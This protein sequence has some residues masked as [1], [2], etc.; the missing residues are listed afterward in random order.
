MRSA[1]GAGKSVVNEAT[2][3][4]ETFHVVIPHGD[5]LKCSRCEAVRSAAASSTTPCVPTVASGKCG[6]GHGKHLHRNVAV[7]PGTRKAAYLAHRTQ[8]RATRDSVAKGEALPVVSKKRRVP[9]L[10]GGRPADNFAARCFWRVLRLLLLVVFLG[11]A[12]S[13]KP[14]CAGNQMASA[15]TRATFALLLAWVVQVMCPCS[16]TK[17]T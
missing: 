3:G 6:T 1:P 8:Q 13:W 11:F 10:A 16:K 5:Q 17:P 15:L 14:A 9:G 4:D 12:L 7:D 2:D